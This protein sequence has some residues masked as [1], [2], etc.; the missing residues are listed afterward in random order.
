MQFFILVCFFTIGIRKNIFVSNPCIGFEAKNIET[1]FSLSPPQAKIFGKW[2]W[3]STWQVKILQK[4]HKKNLETYLMTKMI[5]IMNKNENSR[6]NLRNKWI[7]MKKLEI[8]IKNEKK[9]E[10]KMTSGQPVTSVQKSS[11]SD[12]QFWKYKVKRVI[13][14]PF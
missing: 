6:K 14:K 9:N 13:F 5:K 11:K 12:A 2:L 7:K 3:K 1:K 10:K 8:F 4:Q